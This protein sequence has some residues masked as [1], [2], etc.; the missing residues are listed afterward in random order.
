MKKQLP[1]TPWHIGSPKMKESDHRRLNKW[2]VHYDSSFCTEPKSGCYMLRCGGSSHCKFYAED[3]KESKKIERDNRTQMEIDTEHRRQYVETLQP[4]M[5]ALVS[6]SD[7]RRY[8][9]VQSLKSCYI[10]GSKLLELGKGRKQCTLCHMEYIDQ[11]SPLSDHKVIDGHDVYVMGQKKPEKAQDTHN[12]VQCQFCD[13]IGRCR[14]KESPLF[15]KRCK[16]KYCKNL[17]KQ[18]MRTKNLE[19]NAF[20]GI[21]N[22]PLDR[23]IVRNMTTPRQ[24]KL[25]RAVEMIRR[26]GG[27]D[28][29]IYVELANDKY[30]LKDGYIRYLAALHCGL[31][32]IPATLEWELVQ[33]K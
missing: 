1:D 28:K 23:I 9:S 13:G 17:K 24:N 33:K 20:T 27:V 14:D 16:P 19:E 29:P 5:Q 7:G 8:I 3:E 6:S 32:S 26:N 10:C 22:I 4:K 11:I 25:D 31:Y 2:C 21:K 12:I 18:I 15:Q 30:L